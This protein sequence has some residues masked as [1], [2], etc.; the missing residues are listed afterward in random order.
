M[1][2]F[3]SGGRCISRPFAQ[4]LL[5]TLRQQTRPTSRR[6]LLTA[7]CADPANGL[8]EEQRQIQKMALDFAA[9]ELAPNMQEWDEKEIFPVE[10]MRKAAQLGFG[11]VYCDEKFGGTGLSRLDASVIFEALATGCCSTTAYISIHNMCAWMVDHFGND[12][13]RSQWVPRLASMDTFSSYCLTEP[14]AGSDAAS[15]ST[16]A[17]KD[18]SHYV[19]NGSKAFISGGGESDLY[20]VMCRTGQ[21][22]P[23]GV[24]CILVEKGTP[25][26]SFAKKE[27][28]LGW[29]SHPARIVNFDD[30]RVPVTNL[31]GEE[32]QGFSIAMKGLNGGRINV[33]SSSLGAAYA[34][35]EQARDYMKIRKQFGKSLENFQ[36]LQF[37][38]AEMAT[39]LVASRLIVRNAAVALDSQDPNA[40]A[41]CS[42]AKL[43]ATE[44]CF[45]ICNSAMQ[46]FG[47]YGYLKDYPVQQYMRDCRVH[48]I[49]EGTNE[50]MRMLVS[51]DLLTER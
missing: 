20:V 31:V 24:S 26:L 35:L 16:T 18:G 34:A 6:F 19:I 13:L 29:N 7:S 47:G 12:E 22:G 11:A 14:G 3:A 33:A 25:G 51:R 42:M 44:E 37:R 10:T 21:A 38:L 46:I 40:V 4:A 30:C 8:G 27:K 15:L 28:K 9:K 50:I 23:A 49:L 17:R 1:A 41:L 39:Q 5:N 32:G 36:Y 2:T 43:F 45:K 48:C